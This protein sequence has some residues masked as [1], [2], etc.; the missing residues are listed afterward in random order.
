MGDRGGSARLVD[1]SRPR[2]HGGLGGHPP[3]ES[4]IPAGD[5]AGSATARRW[6]RLVPPSRD[7]PPG[8]PSGV[9]TVPLTAD[10]GLEQLGH[11]LRRKGCHP[12]AALGLGHLV[13]SSFTA[14]VD[15]GS[16]G[17]GQ[18]DKRATARAPPDVPEFHVPSIDGDWSP[19]E[20]RGIPPQGYG[21]SSYARLTDRYLAPAWWPAAAGRRTAGALKPRRVGLA[22][23]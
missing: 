21:R 10:D 18:N 5:G 19:H 12:A 4:H 1:E 23:W 8:V 22:R 15:G 9:R 6:R 14:F 13:Q 11:P 16:A 2:Q 20:K 3:L 7:H 17:R